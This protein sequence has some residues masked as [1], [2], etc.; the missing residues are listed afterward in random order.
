[1]T[2]YVTTTI[3]ITMILFLDVIVKFIGNMV[4]IRGSA[5]VS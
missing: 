1:M 3:I 5:E 2:H 4:V